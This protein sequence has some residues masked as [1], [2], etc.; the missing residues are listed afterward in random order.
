MQPS[1]LT[2]LN[3]NRIPAAL[4]KHLGT[5]GTYSEDILAGDCIVP[6][7]PFDVIMGSCAAI[8]E[9]YERRRLVAN[10]YL[11][12]QACQ[13]ARTKELDSIAKGTELD[14]WE[15]PLPPGTDT[16]LITSFRTRRDFTFQET[17]VLCPELLGHITREFKRKS[18]KLITFD[19]VHDNHGS[20]QARV[21]N[22]L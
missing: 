22:R 8:P 5:I 21:V 16:H 6:T 2:L 17:E 13:S 20:L 19:R 10:L 3:D 7:V 18:Y 15:T 9:E 12:T 1:F 11:L 4:I 14:D